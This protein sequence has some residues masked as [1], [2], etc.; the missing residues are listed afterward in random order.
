MSDID[1]EHAKAAHSHGAK[2]GKLPKE[3][4]PEP[5]EEHDHEVCPDCGDK[6]RV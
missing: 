5:Q 2:G 3:I 1:R 4:K 6:H